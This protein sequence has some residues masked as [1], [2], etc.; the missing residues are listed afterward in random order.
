M[1]A[2]KHLMLG[3]TA[4]DFSADTSRG[5]IKFYDWL[6]ASW[7]CVKRPPPSVFLAFLSSFS[8][9]TSM[10]RS[11]QCFVGLTSCIP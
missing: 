1:A 10:R 6:G 7:G 8:L 4:P 3:D 9:V 11:S 5:P 2:N